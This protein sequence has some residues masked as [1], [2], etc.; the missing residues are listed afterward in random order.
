MPNLPAGNEWLK[1]RF[2]LNNYSFTHGSYIGGYD[3]I[4]LTSHG[5]VEQ[6]YRTRYA[7]E[8]T[9]L[10]HIEFAL[11]YDDLNLDFLSAVFAYIDMDE[12]VTFISTTPSGRYARA[13]GF[14]YEW[15][16]GQKLV[17]EK[18][19]SGNYIDLL[20]V[21][22]YVTGN[23]VKNSRWRINNN[24]LGSPAFCPMIRRTKKLNELLEQN[25]AEQIDGLKK[26]FPEDIFRRAISYLYSKETQSSYAI[27]QETPSPD[28]ME[29][30]IA[31]LQEAGDQPAESILTRAAL[32]ALQ[33]AIVDKRFAA[34]DFRNF[35]NYVGQSLSNYKTR[36]HYICPPPDMVNSLMEGLQS[37]A[38]KTAGIN[39]IVRAAM[40]AFG[41]V[42]IHPFEDGNGRLHRFLIHDVLS[43]DGLVPKGIII[44]VSG[45]ML[46]HKRAYDQVLETYSRPLMQRIKYQMS[47]G[48]EV[49]IEHPE[50]V[51]NYFRYP[52]LTAHA[53]Y[54]AETIHETLKEDMPDELQFLLRYEE[55]KR[56]IQKIVD[57]PDKDINWMIIFLHQNKGLFPKRRRDQFPKLTD[58]EIARMQE[59]YVH[60]YETTL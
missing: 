30:F 41:F 48:G 24:M 7:P 47:A 12:I 51:I 60:V 5:N 6:V 46:N 10:A 29:R 27:E 35:Q 43:H 44:P 2:E 54:L 50:E 25:V 16:T 33:S 31:L 13:I 32:A 11:K 36:V 59:A 14:L 42:F 55:A 9:S 26:E 40:L 8:E 21:D 57:M 49:T 39:P 17:L 38:A 23:T 4:E 34:R 53:V 45:H 20:D 3:S 15:L 37:S 58:E 52:D 1:A 19:I 22:R 28:R 56:E 18:P